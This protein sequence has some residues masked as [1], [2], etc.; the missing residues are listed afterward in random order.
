MSKTSLRYKILIALVLV[1]F[2]SIS[3]LITALQGYLKKA[4][5]EQ[6]TKRAVSIAKTM[7]EQ[8][9][10]PILTRNYLV[11]NLMLHETQKNDPDIDYF[12]VI[13]PQKLVTAHTFNDGFPIGLKGLNGQNS[14]NSFTHVKLGGRLIYDVAVP[15]MRGNLGYIHVGI[16]EKNIRDEI[17]NIIIRILSIISAFFLAATI[18]I[19]IFLERVALRPV[20]RL[21]QQVRQLR[22]KRFYSGNATDS[23]DEIEEMGATFNEIEGRLDQLYAQAERSGELELLNEKLGKLATTDGLTGLFNSRHFYERLEEEVH[24]AKR[25]GNP[26]TLIMADIDHFKRYNDTMGHVAGDVALKTI[27]RI[28][29]E[30]A[31]DNDLVC[32]YGG[33]EMAIILPETDLKTAIVVAERI[34]SRIVCVSE[35]VAQYQPE[36]HVTASFGV[37]QMDSTIDSAK[38]LVELADQ[39]LYRAKM[40]GR[41]RIES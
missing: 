13:D 20:E 31:R 29:S 36:G 12:F 23:E 3:L 7:A 9:L 17:I 21:K 16:S 30:N 18:V 35:L 5:E 38:S 24:R 10:N 26:L 34:K 33:E 2:C 1:S 15:L 14:S 28:I 40:N 6:L 27:A 39:A 11:L 32:R 37:A 19:W 25:Y 4:L 8:C 41:N 22:Q